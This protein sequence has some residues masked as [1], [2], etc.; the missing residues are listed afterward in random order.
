[1]SQFSKFIIKYNVKL[2]ISE[3]RLIFDFFENLQ[4]QGKI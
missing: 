3:N 4:V 1:M 2:N